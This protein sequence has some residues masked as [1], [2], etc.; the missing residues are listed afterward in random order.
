[1]K[2]VLFVLMLV[3]PVLAGALEVRAYLASKAGIYE[4]PVGGEGW[5]QEEKFQSHQNHMCGLEL[6]DA[7][8]SI[9]FYLGTF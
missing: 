7:F 4:P 9:H 1:M 8:L 5:L 2:V 3:N 6:L